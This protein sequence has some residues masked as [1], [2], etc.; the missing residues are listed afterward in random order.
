MTTMHP[1]GPATPAAAGAAL[2]DVWPQATC[3][4]CGPAN[5]SGLQIKSY[6]DADGESVICLFQPGPQH[7][8]GFPNVMYGGLVASLIDCHSIWTAIAATYKAAGQAY[9]SRPTISYVTGA[10]NVRYLAPTPLD[11]P[12]LLRARVTELHPR[13]AL[14]TCT[15]QAGERVTAEGSVVAVRV[16]DDKSRG[17]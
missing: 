14:V 17:A 12:T 11:T 5:P 4:G 16:D 6:W 9:G 3:Y 10:L 15:V 7:N 13:K 8:A 2:Q 1:D